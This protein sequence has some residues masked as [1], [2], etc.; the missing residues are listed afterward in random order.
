MLSW[1]LSDGPREVAKASRGRAAAMA[2][3]RSD[4]GG[5]SVAATKANL[6]GVPRTGQR[7]HTRARGRDAIQRTAP[8]SSQG[9]ARLFNRRSH[10]PVIALHPVS[11]CGH[12][13]ETGSLLSMLDGVA[14]HRD[15]ALGDQRVTVG[16][17]QNHH[18]TSRDEVEPRAHSVEEDEVAHLPARATV[19][20]AWDGRAAQWLH[21]RSKVGCAAGTG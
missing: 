21:T 18:V 9:R 15:D 5:R 17:A 11:P 8:G 2:P 10:L 3:L 4:G 13:H 16:R 6:A 12:A 7:T 14:A 20:L 19:V 1:I